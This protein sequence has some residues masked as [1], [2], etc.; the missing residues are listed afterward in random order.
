[1]AHIMS[2]N[3]NDN[4]VLYTIPVTPA[5]LDQFILVLNLS[6]QSSYR[7]IS[8]ASKW[9]LDYKLSLDKIHQSIVKHDTSIARIHS[10]ENLKQVCCCANDEL[11]QSNTPILAGAHPHSLY[12]YLLTRET[13][14]DYETWAINLLGG[15]WKN[16]QNLGL[17]EKDL[18]LEAIMNCAKISVF[19]ILSE[20]YCDYFLVTRLFKLAL[21]S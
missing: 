18:L 8:L 15:L 12:C 5:W 7:R 19:S 4:E 2:D 17:R 13:H 3:K 11:F 9:L 1:M 21:K 10:T 20:S 6:G 14:R 16:R